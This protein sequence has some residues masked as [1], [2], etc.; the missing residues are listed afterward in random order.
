MAAF[1]RRFT[2]ENALHGIEVVNGFWF[3]MK[4]LDWCVDKN[5]AV[6]NF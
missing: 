2:Q 5:L 1:L 3:Y 6:M 4:A